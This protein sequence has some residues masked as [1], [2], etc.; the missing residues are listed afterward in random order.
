V[1]TGGSEPRRIEQ[2][3]VV[4]RGAVDAVDERTVGG[5]AVVVACGARA[6]AVRTTLPAVRTRSVVLTSTPPPERGASP[7]TVTPKRRSAPLDCTRRSCSSTVFSGRTHPA[8]SS[9][10]ATSP[11]ARRFCSQRSWTWSAVSFSCGRSW[12]RGT[13]VEPADVVDDV[14]VL[15]EVIPELEGA[16]EQRDIGVPSMYLIRIIRDPPWKESQKKGRSRER[17][18]MP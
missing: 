8:V 11:G 3:D 16:S 13:G 1:T 2:R 15:I 12:I 10:T 5:V 9:N 7:V 18:L 4:A 6:P 17:S 14:C